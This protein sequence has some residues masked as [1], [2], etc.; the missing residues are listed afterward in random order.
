MQFSR[1]DTCRTPFGLGSNHRDRTSGCLVIALLA[2]VALLNPV[3]LGTSSG[4]APTAVVQ[5]GSTSTA[6]AILTTTPLNLTQPNL[7]ASRSLQMSSWSS[8]STTSRT[9]INSTDAQ[10][11]TV[12]LVWRLDQSGMALAQTIKYDF[13]LATSVPIPGPSGPRITA[14]LQLTSSTYNSWYA[15]NR[16][17]VYPNNTKTIN[18][19]NIEGSYANG[20]SRKSLL[21]QAQRIIDA[22]AGNSATLFQ[23]E[24]PGYA[25]GDGAFHRYSIEIDLQSNRTIWIVDNTIIAMFN[26]SFIPANMILI[27]SANGVGDLAVATLKDPV[28]TALLPLVPI[29]ST[30]FGASTPITLS[31]S[32]SGQVQI[33]NFTIPQGQISSLQSQI[34][35]LN[36]QVGSLTTQNSQL[37]AKNSQWFSQWWISIVWGLL[38][39]V[40]GGFVF[41][42]S[43]RIRTGRKS[44]TT[45]S[46]R[47]GSCPNC[48]GQM[49]TGATFCGV[50]GTTL[51]E[52]RSICPGC[53]EQMPAASLYCGDCGSQIPV[54]NPAYQNGSHTSA[55]GS[56]NEDQEAW[57]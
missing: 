45:E 23:Q 7:N 36:G 40:V 29:T 26:L 3:L 31:I 21:L 54:G 17:P 37:Q 46:G 39:A 2:V 20:S 53:G 6:N 4:H 33:S 16:T 51:R 34:D 30:T 19:S 13:E 52:I 22:S 35:R 38:G 56:T 47:T 49:P 41:V 42:S 50:C 11:E 43:A 12:S 25:A 10:G 44:V 8:N 28:Q 15:Q 1:R 27:T 32:S 57:R 24:F 48:G 5:S 55:S 14:S 18:I 9:I